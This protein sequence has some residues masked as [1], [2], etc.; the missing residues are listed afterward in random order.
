VPTGPEVGLKVAAAVVN[1]KALLNVW[2]PLI[3]A[4]IMTVLVVTPEGTVI[5]PE[6]AP[7]LFIDNVS[8]AAIPPT[9]TLILESAAVAQPDPV[10]FILVPTGPDIGVKV[11]LTVVTVKALLNVWVKVWIPVMTIILAPVPNVEG[12][13]IVPDREPLLFTINVLVA[14]VPLT[15]TPE[16]VSESAQPDPVT[17]ILVP[18]GPEA[19]LN[20][21][22]TVVT[23]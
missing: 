3:A 21:A 6:I 19:G 13:V 11:G 23:I 18:T 4:F 15:V 5:L 16:M 2:V 22:V 1:V 20:A 17:V 9:V 8:V 7:L 10:T 12:T 14:V